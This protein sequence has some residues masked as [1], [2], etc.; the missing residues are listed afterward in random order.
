MWIIISAAVV[1]AIIGG[2]GRLVVPGRQ[3]IGI[4][5]TIVLGWVGSLIGSLIG[6]H[7]LHVGQI[8]TVL[9]EIGVAAV[10]VAIASSRAGNA[11]AGRTRSL[12]W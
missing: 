8:L 4:L 12:R 5:A 10:L 1:G 9:C 3:Q 6:R 11:L 7:I 2:L